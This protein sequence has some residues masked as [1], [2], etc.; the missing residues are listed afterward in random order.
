MKMKSLRFLLIIASVCLGSCSKSRY[1]QVAP[2]IRTQR[3]IDSLRD[4]L[5]ASNEG[6]LM[7]YFPNADSLLF[8]KPNQLYGH[9]EFRSL[10]GIGGYTYGINFKSDGSVEMRSD[11]SNTTIL[12]A[13]TSKYS[14]HQGSATLLSLSTYNY[15]HEL[16]N[17][18]FLGSSDFLYQGT[19]VSG[20]LVF[21]TNRY[22]EY[23][24]EFIRLQRISSET[25]LPDALSLSLKHRKSFED[26]INPQLIIRQGH[27]EYFRGN[28]YIKRRIS[29]NM[30]FINEI[31]NRRYYAFLYSAQPGEESF[32][33]FKG[34]S[35]LGSG[36]T[37]TQE[38]LTFYPGLTYSNTLRFRDF[39]Y[40]NNRFIAELVYVYDPILRTQRLESKH[41]YPQG[42]ETGY[43]A[44][45]WDEPV[46]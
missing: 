39:E 2:N 25:K 20:A 1:D 7:T 10:Y 19:D 37:G 43:V 46:N 23:G 8:S 21:S 4:L 5:L 28:Y 44:E 38:G 41:L 42:I 17:N 33:F 31:T 6:W 22:T 27:R 24:H 34:F 30:P 15:P 26:M 13:K 16:V 3:A 18:Q 35:I 9:H 32:S 11:A 40:K 12:E 36:Y 29:T 14:I 45:I